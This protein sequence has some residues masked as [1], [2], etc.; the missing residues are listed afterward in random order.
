MPL[1]YSLSKIGTHITESQIT[2]DEH[3]LDIDPELL[4]NGL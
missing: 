3:Q 4:G 2:Y 1:I